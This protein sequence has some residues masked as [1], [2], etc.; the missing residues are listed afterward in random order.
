MDRLLPTL[1]IVAF[2]AGIFA[3]MWWGW[4]ARV[5]RQSGYASPKPVPEIVGEEIVAPLALYLSTTPAGQPME[6]LA[7]PVLA[8][9]AQAVL[10]V[11][12][13]GVVLQLTGSKRLY[14]PASDILGIGTATI[15]IDRVVEKDGLVRLS[16][17]LGDDP[18][19]S[20]FRL[21]D[22]NDR[23]GLF[24]A[25]RRLAPPTASVA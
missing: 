15:T 16:W 13:S 1:I 12:E 21:A 20:Y 3:L 7:L 5:R 9:R 11:T 2:V 10:Q 23:L 14:I 4:R 6:R 8:F 18:V 25:V 24:D 17:Q 19:D 22:E